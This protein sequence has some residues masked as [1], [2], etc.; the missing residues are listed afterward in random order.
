MTHLELGECMKMSA[1]DAH[2]APLGSWCRGRVPTEHGTPPAAVRTGIRFP[3]FERFQPFTTQENR[4][5][6]N[7]RRRKK[8]KRVSILFILR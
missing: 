1:P 2:E 3:R 8:E 7:E 6:K 4:K 5:L